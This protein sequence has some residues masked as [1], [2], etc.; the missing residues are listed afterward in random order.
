M[1]MAAFVAAT[2]CLALVTGAFAA[3]AETHAGMVL[4]RGGEFSMGMVDPR[5]VTGG[6]SESM[7]D[8]R[9]VHRVAV[10]SFWMDETDVTNAAFA[11]FVRATAYVT[12]AERP[13]D[14]RQFPNA[15]AS[16]VK[17]G[18]VV[19]T[20]PEHPVSLA[21]PNGW[22]RYVPGAN[23]QHPRG[24]ASSIVGHDHDPVVQI[25]YEDA[26]AYARWAGKR[27]PTEAEWERAARGGLEQK[28]YAWGNELTPN[29]RWMANIFQGQFPVR[30]TRQDG[31]TD[32][33]PV[34]TF[35][36]NGY[37]LFDMS[38]NVW[39]WVSDWYRPDYY[40]E[41]AAKGL[42]RDPK[43]PPSSRDP[44]EP[45]VPKRVQRGGSFLC[46]DQYCTRY[47]VGARGRG[48]PSTSSNHV[49]FRCVKDA[50]QP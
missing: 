48:E 2:T 14:P 39:Q 24:P 20:Q 23:W 18:G 28:L 5:G 13:L 12:V 43:G 7:S 11:Q 33:A 31:F 49:G 15:P 9:P 25:A 37:G 4:I 36:A 44:L 6:G 26:E 29:G 46:T 30:N 3:G 38:G 8:A 47:M 10:R 45:G 42:A 50:A 1:G 27:L 22:W 32:T 21:D 35:P 34:R 41:L 17:P 40:A 16:M 19:F